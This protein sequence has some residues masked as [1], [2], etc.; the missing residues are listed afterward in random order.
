[1]DDYEY[2]RLCDEFLG[3]LG[4]MRTPTIMS[5]PFTCF[6]C[7][8]AASP[9]PNSSSL[10]TSYHC[11]KCQNEYQTWRARYSREN[12]EWAVQQYYK[13]QA[14]HRGWPMNPLQ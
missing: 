12:P 8:G 14:G 11:A 3:L 5:G 10:T 7:K 4:T 6:R 1:M 2:R 13:Q 9:M